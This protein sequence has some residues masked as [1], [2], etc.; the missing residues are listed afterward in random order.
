MKTGHYTNKQEKLQK[1]L[2]KYLA[3]LEKSLIYEYG[4]EKAQAI[5]DTSLS[6]YPD[7]IPYI[8]FFKTPMYDSLVLLNSRMMALKKGMRS[9]QIDVKEFVRFQVN[10]LR[11]NMES[12]PTA[13]RSL[14][15]KIFLSKPVSLILNNTA[16]KTTKNGWPTQVESGARTDNFSMKVHT[17][18]CQMVSF[19][20]S[21][22]EEDLIPY[23]S[24]ADFTNAESLGFGLKQTSTIDSGTCTFC[25]SKKGD[26]EWPEQIREV[27]N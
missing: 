18:N 12:K 6:S 15:G 21:V 24:F 10:D 22:G 11:S 19:M 4:D 2:N 17:Q 3:G 7:I 1:S 5:I 16:R 8:P 27:L 9:Q 14:L 20:R 13:I 23:C 25:F 26:V